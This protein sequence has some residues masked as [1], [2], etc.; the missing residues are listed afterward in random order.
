MNIHICDSISVLDINEIDISTFL[1]GTNEEKREIALLFDKTF[2]EYGI[3]RLINTNITSELI[4]RAKEFFSLDLETK[5]KYSENASNRK[6]FGY[7]PPG[8]EFAAGY[9]KTTTPDSVEVFYYH[10]KTRSKQINFSL[11]ESPELFRDVVIEYVMKT[12]QLLSYIHNIADMALELPENTFDEKYINDDALFA[13]RIAK[14]LPT[15]N[16]EQLALGEH[17]DY[18]GFTLLQND[19]VPGMYRYCVVC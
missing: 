4:D 10:F 11:D 6:T 16:K 5:Q 19:N 9:K 12:R 15:I 14:Y 8:I 2:H 1:N 13:L 7:K 17:Q 3:I 18:F